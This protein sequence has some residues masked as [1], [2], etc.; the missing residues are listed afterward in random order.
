M[1]LIIVETVNDF[2]SLKKILSKS[3]DILVLRNSEMIILDE[4][5]V[6]YKVIEDFYPMDQFHHDTSFF[7]LEV[8][9]LFTKLD[10][11]CEKYISF[12][13]A[14]SGNEQYFLS[15]FD[16]LFYL[17]KLIKIIKKRYD[18]IYLYSTSEHDEL[19]IFS[20]NVNNLNSKSINGT[21]SF[22]AERSFKRVIQHLYSSLSVSII[23]DK[24]LLQKKIPIKYQLKKYISKFQ[25]ISF[26]KIFNQKNN[27]SNKLNGNTSVFIINDGYELKKLK[28]YLPNLKY[29]SPTIKLRQEILALKPQDLSTLSVK[30]IFGPFLEKYFFFLKHYLNSIMILYHI[31]IVGRISYFKV[32]FEILTKEKK[33]SLFLLSTGTRDVFDT[34]CCFVANNYNIPVIIFQHAGSSTLYN[35]PYAKSLEYNTRVVKTIISQSKRD[36]N[37]Y[38][39]KFTEVLCLGSIQDYELNKQKNKSINKNILFCLGPDTESSFRNF[40]SVYKKYNQSLDILSTLNN[41]SLPLDLKLHPT[42]Q[43]NSLNGYLKILK[44][45]KF[46]KV[47][48]I[49]GNSV[50]LISKKYDLFIIDFLG[51]AII[52]H[53]M[54]LKVPIIIYDSL[55]EKIPIESSVLKDIYKRF[56]I[57]R[58]SSELYELLES[59]KNGILPSKWSNE[60]IDDYIY[61]IKNGH[62]GKNISKYI[63][64][65]LL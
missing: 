44:K 54:S 1:E 47:N 48:I 16:D 31:E 12:P 64:N 37:K 6:S 55:F 10:L 18:K 46:N 30:S 29:L 8:E 24:F 13:F 58:N 49:Y 9:K 45:N 51:S 40:H 34:I 39:N 42:G 52:K 43:E 3:K 36:Y 53:I 2:P 25:K 62:P 28:Q 5:N 65:L 22:A 14:Y 59:Y 21:I 23:K 56:Y 35:S 19:S 41:M 57:A 61:P 26:K 7:R 20:L 38:Q 11:A 33:P 32:K 4:N 50:E 60:I 15:W 27:K 63:E 17:E